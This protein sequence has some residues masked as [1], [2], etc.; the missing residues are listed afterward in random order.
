MLFVGNSYVFTN[1]LDQVVEALFAS[2]DAASWGDAP[3]ARLAQGGYRFVDHVAQTEASGSAWQD[4]LVTGSTDWGWV[5]LQEQSQIP[6]FP[7]SEAE[8]VNSLAAADTL[9]GLVEER[10]DQTVLL[11]TWGRRDGDATNP[12]LY[13]DFPTMQARL[14]EG[15]RTYADEL[16]TEARPVWIAPAGLAWQA[17]YDEVVAE[18][19]DPLAPTSPFYALYVSDGSHPSVGGTYLIACVVYA[20][21]TG[22]SPVGAWAPEPLD[23]TVAAY[24]QDVAARVVLTDDPTILYPWEVE[25]GGDS[26]SDSGA[27]SGD[28]AGDSGDTGADSGDSGV[29]SG[30]SGDGAGDSGAPAGGC[31]CGTGGAGPSWLVAVGALVAGLARRR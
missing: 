17:V 5:V 4:A 27:D 30:D 16:S 1:D 9:D 18:G 21:V 11:M 7:H 8:W 20:T 25:D 15:Y 10:S 22:D 12:S 26:G 6:G 3:F 28:S 13:P 19:G 29:D 23:A 31:G 24:L 2:E 14:S